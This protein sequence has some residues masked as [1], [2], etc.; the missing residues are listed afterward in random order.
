MERSRVRKPAAD[1]FALPCSIELDQQPLV[2]TAANLFKEMC[3]RYREDLTAGILVAGWDRRKGGQV[4]GSCCASFSLGGGT[5]RHPSHSL[6]T[7]AAP[8]A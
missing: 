1:S 5:L 3:Y 2:H 8:S 4:R 7:L 6:S